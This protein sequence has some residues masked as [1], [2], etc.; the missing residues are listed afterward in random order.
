MH[1]SSSGLNWFFDLHTVCNV[2]LLFVRFC[3]FN[4]FSEQIKCSL[5]LLVC[6]VVF[7]E[8]YKVT[9]RQEFFQYFFV[10]ACKDI[11]AGKLG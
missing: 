1:L 5:D 4:E 2:N 11:S 6:R 3:F 10:G 7:C 9:M 8:F